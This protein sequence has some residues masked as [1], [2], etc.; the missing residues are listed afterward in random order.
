MQTVLLVTLALGALLGVVL[1][2]FFR[3]GNA[4]SRLGRERVLAR[5]SKEASGTQ[6][7]QAGLDTLFGGPPKPRREAGQQRDAPQPV[8]EPVQ[9]VGVDF[10]SE[11][12]ELLEQELAR[13]PERSDLR[14]KLLEMYAE[15]QR[16]AEFVA[17]AHKHFRARQGDPDS[18]WTRI[19]EMGSRLVPGEPL[20]A[21]AGPDAASGSAIEAAR[22]A[23]QK[24]RRYYDSLYPQVLSGLQAD[25]HKAYESVRNDAEFWKRLGE[26]CAGFIGPRAPLMHAAKLSSFVGGARIYVKIDV[27][28]PVSSAAT[29][30]AVG[31]ALIA[32][33]MGRRRLIAGLASDGHAIA[34]AGA[35]RALGLEAHIVVTERERMLCAEELL[36]VTELGARLLVI[37]DG[38][39]GVNTEGQRGALADALEDS[40]DTLYVSP[41]EAGPFPYPVIAHE[42]QGLASRELKAEVIALTGRAPDGVIVSTSDGMSAIGHLQAFL[43][44]SEVQLRC[45]ETRP[46]LGPGRARFDR[47]HAWLRAT[48]RVQYSTLSENVAAFAARYCFPDGAGDLHLAGGQMLVETFALSRQFTPEQVVAV[49]IPPEAATLNPA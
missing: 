24:F 16:K 22:D 43:G 25:L 41:L 35:A 21:G 13:S 4:E 40:A 37:P 45:V 2:Q 23:P 9:E 7:K 5:K 48:G 38:P 36:S 47:E 19:V 34:V 20:F 15:T 28:R 12:V 14:F 6:T 42:L 26:L 1:F 17:L 39:P 33:A 32:Q 30:G 8:A 44:A 18:Q 46:A 3:R 27:E 11:V 31:Q 49:V 10:Y 29:I